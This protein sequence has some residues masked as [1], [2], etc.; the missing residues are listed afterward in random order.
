MKY[1]T[2][3]FYEIMLYFTRYFVCNEN[4]REYL[5]ARTINPLSGIHTYGRFHPLFVLQTRKFEEEIITNN[6]ICF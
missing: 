4:A 1:F 2:L 5:G 3:V 6:A